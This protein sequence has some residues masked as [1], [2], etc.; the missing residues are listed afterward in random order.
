MKFCLVGLIR[1]MLGFESICDLV[2]LDV[3]CCV[4]I[5]IKLVVYD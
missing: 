5:F 2:V 1:L 3:Y 4:F